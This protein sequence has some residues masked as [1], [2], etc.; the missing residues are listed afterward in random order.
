MCS[1]P[2]PCFQQGLLTKSVGPL[3]VPSNQPLEKETHA[4]T[5]YEY[6][7]TLPVFL[8][9]ADKMLTFL[10]AIFPKIGQLVVLHAFTANG[11]PAKWFANLPTCPLEMPR[12]CAF[13]VVEQT[14]HIV[15][16]SLCFAIKTSAKN[17]PLVL[18]QG[19]VF[20]FLQETSGW[21]SHFAPA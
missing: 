20:P 10:T 7:R 19:A 1:A 14:C 5:S 12:C 11:A 21:V 6:L 17:V 15:C 8:P 2:V 13:L 3:E 18:P 4:L 16:F 9:R